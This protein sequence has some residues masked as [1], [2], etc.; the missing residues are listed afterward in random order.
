MSTANQKPRAVVFGLDD[1]PEGDRQ[2]LFK[3]ARKLHLPLDA[4][5]LRAPLVLAQASAPLHGVPLRSDPELLTS[6]PP[7]LL[8]ATRLLL[9]DAY[10][11]PEQD[12]LNEDPSWMEDEAGY[13]IYAADPNEWT[14][15]AL[16]DALQ[17]RAHMNVQRGLSPRLRPPTFAG[18]RVP[19]LGFYV[20][21]LGSSQ[22]S[23]RDLRDVDQRTYNL[24]GER[25][26][27]GMIPG[28]TAGR[29]RLFLRVVQALRHSS[30][31]QVEVLVGDDRTCVIRKAEMELHIADP[32]EDVLCEIDSNEGLAE[33]LSDVLPGCLLC[34]PAGGLILVD[35]FRLGFSVVKGHLPVL[36]GIEGHGDTL[37]WAPLVE[38]SLFGPTELGSL[39]CPEETKVSGSGRFLFFRFVGRCDG[40]PLDGYLLLEGGKTSARALGWPM[41]LDGPTPP[42]AIS[43]D[44][45]TLALALPPLEV[46]SPL[47]P[48]CVVEESPLVPSPCG[49]V[50]FYELADPLR[51]VGEVALP[52]CTVAPQIAFVPGTGGVLLCGD[53][54]TGATWVVVV[55][56][57][58]L[59]KPTKADVRALLLQDGGGPL[60]RVVR[61][62]AD[63]ASEDDLA[64]CPALLALR[65][66]G[67]SLG[68]LTREA[69]RIL[70]DPGSA[71]EAV[72]AL[73]V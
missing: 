56:Q 6:G 63:G 64:P 46:R 44:E 38:R 62:L 39:L 34:T 42:L 16:A 18:D 43:E 13:I 17:K 2:H 8:L 35:L 19:L 67:I 33:L 73:R 53:P 32:G 23:V 4:S 69:P 36:Q 57:R 58:A 71:V 72:L 59:R 29:F 7:F 65:A 47:S 48:C 30:L 5:A 40:Q 10:H 21:A 20:P 11:W 41:D 22:S 14:Q 26:P 61:E 31:V 45:R 52:G 70:Q 3:I 25:L 1:L 68:L 28:N 50:L 12:F 54:R 49:K 55:E 27:Q 37:E 15:D 60:L 24:Y 66:A 9:A 51:P